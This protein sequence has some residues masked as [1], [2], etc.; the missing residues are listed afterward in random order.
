M[1]AYCMWINTMLRRLSPF[2]AVFQAQGLHVGV[3]TLEHMSSL[4]PLESTDGGGWVP[5]THSCQHSN[6][7]RSAVD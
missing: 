5:C 7:L 4:V 1:H 6:V 3:C 2:N